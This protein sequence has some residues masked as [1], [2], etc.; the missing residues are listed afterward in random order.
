MMK[1]RNAVGRSFL[2]VAVI[3]IVCYLFAGFVAKQQREQS[4]REYQQNAERMEQ[5]TEEF[6]EQMRFQSQQQYHQQY[7]QQMCGW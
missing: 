5:E 3:I 7:T 4:Y 6:R 2:V 1:G